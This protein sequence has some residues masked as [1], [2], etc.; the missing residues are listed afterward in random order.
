MPVL[1]PP[2]L[3]LPPCPRQVITEA[4]DKPRSSVTS[5]GSAADLVTETDVASEAAILAAIQQRFPGHAVLGEEGGVSGARRDGCAVSWWRLR[6]S[7]AAAVGMPRRRLAWGCSHPCQ[8]SLPWRLPTPLHPGD[9]NSEYLWCVDP[10]DGTTN[11]AHGY[12]SFAVSVAV[13]RHTTPVAATGAPSWGGW[14]GGAGE[15]RAGGRAAGRGGRCRTEAACAPTRPAAT[16][17][18]ACSG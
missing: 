13:L 15:G 3:L 8:A 10:L 5:K 4:L 16:A 7:E 6:G 2:L 11:F 1:M 9:T 12:P 14:S 17:A 18:A